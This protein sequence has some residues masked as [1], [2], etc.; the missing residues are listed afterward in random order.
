MMVGMFDGMSFK[1][2]KKAKIGGESFRDKLTAV[3]FELMDFA[4]RCN[5]NGAFIS[6]REIPFT[7]LA[8]IATMIDRDEEELRLCMSFFINEEM[9]TITDDVYSL[10][11][12]SEF[13]NKE[14]LDRI[15]E[16]NRLRKQRQREN[17]KALP[18]VSRDSHVTVTQCHALEEDKERD[19]EIDLEK[20]KEKID[21]QQIADLYNTICVSFPSIRTLSDSRKKAIKARLNTYT[22]DDFK[23]VFQ[24]AEASSFLK[25]GNDR[26]WIANFDWLIKDANMAKVL[27]GNYAN[28][29]KRNGRKEV[30]P[31]WCTDE[32]EDMVQNHIPVYKKTAADDESIR[33]RAEALQ[34]QL[35]K[36]ER[37]DE[38]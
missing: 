34:K 8:D 15:R 28:K 3:W 11:N 9:V 24:N 12:W 17:Q 36:C 18:Y 22:L 5:H 25:G 27:E 31:N 14:G 10:T 6:P 38:R 32:Y 23:T 4:G 7:D 2:I 19:I 21:C 35:A 26:N 37:K 16:Q 30:V 29:P 1:K 13:Q 33:A 20:E